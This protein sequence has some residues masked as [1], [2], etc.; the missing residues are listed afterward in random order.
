MRDDGP[1][2]DPPTGELTLEMLTESHPDLLSRLTCSQFAG[3]QAG[4]LSWAFFAPLSARCVLV[5]AFVLLAVSPL[6]LHGQTPQQ[7]SFEVASVKANTSGVPQTGG[8]LAGASFSMINE[9][10]WR[11]IGEAYGD[12]QALPR[13]QIV[14]GPGWMDTD[15]FDVDAVASAPLDRRTAALMLRHLL[16]ER[17]KL[18]AHTEQRESPVLAL[19]RARRDG[20]LGEELRRADVD[21]AALAPAETP[22]AVSSGEQP[23]T[24]QFGFGRLSANGLTIHEL[25]TVGLS[26]A[27]GRP[28]IDE[29]NLAGPFRWSLTWTPDHLPRRA[30]GT[31]PDQPVTVNGQSVDPNGPSLFTAIE[32]QLGLKLESSKGSVDVLVIDH[33]E[34]PTPD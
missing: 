2:A 30:L 17:F 26:R 6:S 13:H 12:G 24:M 10:L 4:N 16:A 14:G 31:P 11:L 33:V 22:P 8:R 21:C 7:P 25:A 34:R 1:R 29:T 27:T 32:E 20:A 23:C 15:R 3:L 5:P 18:A 9:T 28:V 19:R